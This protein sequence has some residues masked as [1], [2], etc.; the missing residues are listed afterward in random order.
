MASLQ[1][2]SDSLGCN[3]K[4]REIQVHRSLAIVAWSVHGSMP[5]G[6][7]RHPNFFMNLCNVYEF[8]S[9]S[10]FAAE[11]R[12][13]RLYSGQTMRL[14]PLLPEVQKIVTLIY[15]D[16]KLFCSIVDSS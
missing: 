11:G 7:H 5:K 4:Q 16:K 15:M 14:S 10:S 6:Q 2:L 3:L 12:V 9:A 1:G 8:T 13:N